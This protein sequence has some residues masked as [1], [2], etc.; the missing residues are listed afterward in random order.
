MQDTTAGMPP[1]IPVEKVKAVREL[2]GITAKGV[3]RIDIDLAT[4]RVVVHRVARDEQGRVIVHGVHLA[5]LHD[6]IPLSRTREGV[7]D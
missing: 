3:T 1:V 4:E 2:L 5:R 6:T 7:Q